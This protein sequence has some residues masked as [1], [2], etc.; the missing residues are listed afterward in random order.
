MI[1][2]DLT[3]K[4]NSVVSG[5]DVETLSEWEGSG[6]IIERAVGCRVMHGNRCMSQ[7]SKELL[8]VSDTQCTS[9]RRAECRVVPEVQIN[10][11]H[12]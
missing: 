11:E 6:I 5:I 7:A 2:Y 10:P 9:S 8:Y 3:V 12:I 4:D 1:N